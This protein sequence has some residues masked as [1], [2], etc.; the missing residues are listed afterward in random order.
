MLVLLVLL[1][2]NEEIV[3]ITFWFLCQ[4]QP[5]RVACPPFGATFWANW[6]KL[7]MKAPVVLSV[8]QVL[9]LLVLLAGNEEMIP[10]T[11]WFLCQHQPKRV[12]CPPFG[13]TFWAN[14]QKL[15]MKAPVVLSVSQVLVLLVLLA[16][17]EEIIPITRSLWFLFRG[18]KPGFIPKT[19]IPFLHQ[20]AVYPFRFLLRLPPQR[21]KS[22][23]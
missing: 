6:Q 2:G 23:P 19:S 21:T 5:K 16:G 11:F 9:V 15:A 8:S 20:Q 22:Q 14:W 13:A 12:A 4:H 1:A 17:N 18:P 7:A 3:P 10:I